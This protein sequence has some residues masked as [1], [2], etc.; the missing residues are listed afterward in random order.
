MRVVLLPI[1][2]SLPAAA[3]SGERPVLVPGSFRILVPAQN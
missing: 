2:L 1:A 3:Q